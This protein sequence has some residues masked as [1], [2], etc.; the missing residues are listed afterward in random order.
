MSNTNKEDK[1][2]SFEKAVDD[3]NR[4]AC[5]P[6]D[7][8]LLELY[9]LYK[10]AMEGDSNQEEPWRVQIKQHKKWE[11]WNT[12]WGVH[13]SA[14]ASSYVLYTRKLSKKYGIIW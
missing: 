7:D 3:I 1:R 14:A 13:P 4:L 12:L 11:S 5:R 10:Q 6:N 8:E 2:D 9:G